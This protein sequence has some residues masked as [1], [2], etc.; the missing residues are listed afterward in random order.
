MSAID[1][2]RTLWIRAKRAEFPQWFLDDLYAACERIS[3]AASLQDSTPVAAPA[4]LTDAEDVLLEEIDA[5][6]SALGMPDYDGEDSLA[7]FITK[8][9]ESTR[10][11]SATAAPAPQAPDDEEMQVLEERDRAEE[12]CDELSRAIAQH[13]GVKIGE[14]SN[15]N[16]PWENA[17]EAI[18]AAAPLAPEPP[19][20]PRLPLWCAEHGDK[21]EPKTCDQCRVL[22]A[23]PQNR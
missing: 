5:A 7:Y 23:E 10:R 2:L 20:P 16:Q 12:M 17:L 8:L 21:L 19:Q 1:E 18:R 4:P 11:D 3:A 6:W 14:H 15:L 22:M 13:L 9:R